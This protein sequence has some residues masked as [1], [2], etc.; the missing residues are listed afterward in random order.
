MHLL[1]FEEEILPSLYDDWR[2]QE[3]VVYFP[4]ERINNPSQNNPDE[5]SLFSK[6]Q[7]YPNS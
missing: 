4:P 6:E 1:L 7:C 3:E 5:L 2:W